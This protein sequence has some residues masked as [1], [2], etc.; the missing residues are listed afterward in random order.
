[1]SMRR[2]IYAAHISLEELTSVRDRIGTAKDHVAGLLAEHGPHAA[3]LAPAITKELQRVQGHL[4]RAEQELQM[5][6]DRPSG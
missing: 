2:R 4:A 6:L 5:M 3:G 1:M